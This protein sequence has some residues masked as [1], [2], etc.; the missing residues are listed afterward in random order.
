MNKFSPI[1]IKKVWGK[2]TWLSSTHPNGFQKDFASFLGGEYPLL[3]KIIE[4]EDSLAVQVHPDDEKAE[5]Y[6]HSL[7]GTKCWY[8]LE[9]KP[10]SKIVYGLNGVYTPSELRHSVE[11][12]KLEDC[13]RYVDVKA[14]DFIFLP[15]GTVH[16]FAGGMKLLEIR[17]SSDVAYRLFDFERGRD[18]YVERAISCIKSDRV[19]NV[20][21]APGAFSCPYFT[22]EDIGVEGEYSGVFDKAP[23]KKLPCDHN[24]IYVVEGSGTMNG[25]K[26]NE[27]ELYVATPGET[28]EAI[29]DMHLLKIIPTGPKH[30]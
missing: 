2:E 13:L 16:S 14:G 11:S 3:V 6:E 22:I 29:G 1:E 8:V 17:E 4:A 21:K 12:K 5:L 30:R 10:N 24:L 19:R 27:G 18:C 9:A 23:G 25:I 7:G 15:S 28:L 26:V 20:T